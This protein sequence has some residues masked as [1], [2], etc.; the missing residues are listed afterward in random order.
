MTTVKVTFD[1]KSQIGDDDDDLQ[2][3]DHIL[4]CLEDVTGFKRGQTEDTGRYVVTTFDVPDTKVDAFCYIVDS[5]T[6]M[7]A[8]VEGR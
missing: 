4:G 2:P 6:E 3:S 8:E 1:R 7:V 5:T